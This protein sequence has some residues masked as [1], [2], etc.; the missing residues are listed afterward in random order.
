MKITVLVENTAP[1][2]LIGEHGLSLWI[3]TPQ[4]RVLFDTGQG[5]ALPQNAERLHVPLETADAVVLSHGHYDHTGGVPYALSHAP[6]ARLFLHSGSF[7]SRFSHHKDGHVHAIGMPEASV[8][9]IRNASQP[10][11][12][13]G[14][15]TAVLPGCFVTGTL[16]RRNAIENTGGKFSFDE[17]GSQI[18][19][20]TDDQALWIEAPKGLIVVLGCAHSGVVNTLDYISEVSGQREFYAVLGGMHLN[21]ASPARLEFTIGALERYNVQIIAPGHCTGTGAT[22]FLKQRLPGCVREACSR[23]VFQFD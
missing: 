4:G 11:I 21:S 13:T 22:D 12:F 18:D 1:P 3:E 7:V 16:P 20:I 15:S 9:A 2:E 17:T 10:P 19:P 8:A 14:H 23:T 6:K 5:A